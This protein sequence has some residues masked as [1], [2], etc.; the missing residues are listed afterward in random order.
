M[1]IYGGPE[2]ARLEKS[3]PDEDPEGSLDDYQKLKKKL[4]AY[5]LPKKNK[6]Y[7]RYMFLKTKPEAGEATV[8]YATR[9]R[10]KATGCEFSNTSDDRI[11]EHLIQT[12]ENQMLVQKCISKGWTL[13]QFLAEAGQIEDVS[14]QVQDMKAHPWSKEIARIEQRRNRTLSNSDNLNYG[15]DHRT[16]LCS[17]CGLIRA[18]QK[19]KN[20]SAYG[21]KCE[22][23]KKFNHFTSV[24]R[25]NMWKSDMITASPKQIMH[26]PIKRKDREES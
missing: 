10:E 1:I 22:T 3:L 5:F 18:H 17:Y 13:T 21:V 16:H 20:C 26:D 24:C 15:R 23:C 14:V 6:H 8:S 12:I 2:I 9:L 19:G 7:A 25:G 4:N 11:L